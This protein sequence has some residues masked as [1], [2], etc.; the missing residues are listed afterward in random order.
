[1]SRQIRETYTAQTSGGRLKDAPYKARV[2][3]HLDPSFMGRIKVTL[4]N[5][6][7]N[8]LADDNSVYYAKYLSTFG[9]TTAFEYNGN[10]LDSYSDTQKSF[11]MAFSPPDIG[12]TVIVIFLNG[13][14]N[15]CY[16]IG[17]EQT[18]HMNNMIPGIPVSE[19]FEATP[20]QKKKYGS[21][22]KKLPVAEYNR[23]IY[24]LE[25]ETKTDEV[26]KPV[27][28]FADRLL[29]QGLLL[30]DV[31]G[32]T[33]SSVRRETPSRVS[34]ILTPGPIDRRGDAKKA[35]VGTRQSQTQNPVPVDRL[36][37]TQ[38]VMDDGDDQFQRTTPASEG[39]VDYKNLLDGEKG[40]PNIPYNEH[41]RLRTR[42]GHQIL[43]HNSEDLIYIGN[44]KGTSWIELSSNGKIDIFAE[45]SISIH[46]K[47]DMNFY[48]DRDI[49][50]EAGRNINMKASAEYSKESDTAEKGKIIDDKQFESGRIQLESAFNTNLL[51]GA[52]LKIETREYINEEDEKVDGD[53][54]LNVKGDGRIAIG[55]GTVEDS[56]VFDIRTDG[57]TSLYNTIDFNLLSDENNKFTAL[58]GATDIL[59]GGNHTETASVIHMNGP[60]AAE[61][62]EATL[63]GTILD[64][65]THQNPVTDKD[66]E[67]AS[68]LYLD[69]N[70]QLKSIMKRIPMHE[71]WAL[72]EN[73]APQIL[74]PDDTDRELS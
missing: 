73:Q 38:F 60:Q 74:K 10:N 47:N 66:L 40:T 70:Y 37:G 9:G 1:M 52:N 48:A 43:L 31:R 39:P 22:V 3:G 58:F 33:T 24:K 2:V 18:V 16:Y 28:P 67:W 29:E 21:L 45:D 49:N 4:L 23:R 5:L 17:Q 15:E 32:T 34:G 19:F 53:L 56:Y 59:S 46:T 63:A 41:V 44:A 42:T 62:P 6:Q 7:G 57:S 20:E 8:P 54:D 71:P 61:S 36:G 12:N 51:V 55:E 35:K 30:D 26:K 50:L 27:H 65:P 72:H 14:R 68:T 69:S 64:L 25:K 13:N 11:G